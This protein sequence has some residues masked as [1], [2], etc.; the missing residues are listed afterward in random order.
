MSRLT[1][2]SINT[3]WFFQRATLWE[4]ASKVQV[5]WVCR[6][7]WWI[8]SAG[9]EVLKFTGQK[10]AQRF[11][12]TTKLA[13]IHMLYCYSTTHEWVQYIFLFSLICKG[14]HIMVCTAADS[15]GNKICFPPTARPTADSALAGIC[16]GGR[17]SQTVCNH[18]Q[19]KTLE[20]W[21]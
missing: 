21:H 10:K 5:L 11:K 12:L 3:R 19:P 1:L 2:L 6:K 15:I 18:L 17:R 4:Y 16:E 7:N 20:N 14:E 8:F 13:C 9:E